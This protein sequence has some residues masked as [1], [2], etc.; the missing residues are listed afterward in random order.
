MDRD[1]P[2][3]TEQTH[4]RL[5]VFNTLK[6]V[7]RRVRGLYEGVSRRVREGGNRRVR[8][9]MSELMSERMRSSGGNMSKE[10]GAAI[11]G[12]AVYRSVK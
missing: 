2:R 5:N 10:V 12:G 7:S 11:K 8:E 1:G 3:R 6:G 9:G 4:D